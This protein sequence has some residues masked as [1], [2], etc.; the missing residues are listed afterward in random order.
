MLDENPTRRKT[1]QIFG[2]VAF[3]GTMSLGATPVQGTNDGSRPVL[4]S[5]RRIIRRI[6]MDDGFLRKVKFEVEETN[7]ISVEVRDGEVTTNTESGSYNPAVKPGSTV[8]LGSDE[9]TIDEQAIEVQLSGQT[10]VDSALEGTG[11]EIARQDDPDVIKYKDTTILGTVEQ[12]YAQEMRTR[13]AVLADDSVSPQA[14]SN[15]L[16]AAEC[17]KYTYNGD[18]PSD[19]DD[20]A[21]RT[22]PINVAWDTGNDASDIQ[23]EMQNVG[24]ESPWPSG[25]KY[26]FEDESTV[27]AQDEHVKKNISPDVVPNQYHVRA[28]DLSGVD[29]L[30]VIGAG[31]RDPVDHNQGCEWVGI[32]CDVNWRVSETREE[33]SDDWTDVL[34]KWAGNANID[35]ASGNYDYIRGSV[36]GH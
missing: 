33:V 10:D 14:E 30:A 24:W 2:A 27:K 21:E 20:L 31:H 26:I 1:L 16:L 25:D 35:S 3:G 7:P 19:P 5:G 28:Y 13:D 8:D 18:D 12:H 22:A 34:T 11:L 4:A 9:M 32:G 36:K 17:S 15:P 6:P 29:N 23:A